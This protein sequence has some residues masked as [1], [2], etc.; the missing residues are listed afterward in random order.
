MAN[1]DTRRREIVEAAPAMPTQFPD[2]VVGQV[3]LTQAV[4]PM[5]ETLYNSDEDFVKHAASINKDNSPS[6]RVQFDRCI[7]AQK[8]KAYNTKNGNISMV[9]NALLGPI[10]TAI[11][12]SL[13]R[14]GLAPSQRIAAARNNILTA[15]AHPAE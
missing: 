14:V 10:S 2:A 8:V 12:W 15:R 1:H 3:T 6:G 4:Y 7:L 5:V 11:I 9:A 13:R